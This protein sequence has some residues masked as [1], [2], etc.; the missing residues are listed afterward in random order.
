MQ[1]CDIYDA[2][3]APNCGLHHLCEDPEVMVDSVA[4]FFSQFL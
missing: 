3:M 1:S 2:A 4:V